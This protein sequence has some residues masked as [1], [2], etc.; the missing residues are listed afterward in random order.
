MEND[1]LGTNTA[2]VDV[3]ERRSELYRTLPRSERWPYTL[4]FASVP[5][6]IFILIYN[7][8]NRTDNNDQFVGSWISFTFAC[9]AALFMPTLMRPASRKFEID[10]IILD[11][12][13]EL[14]E[15]HREVVTVS[16]RKLQQT[17]DLAKLAL[18]HL[19]IQ[20]RRIGSDVP[21]CDSQVCN[22]YQ[23]EV[24]RVSR[25]SKAWTQ[26]WAT[27]AIVSAPMLVFISAN[28]GFSKDLIAPTAA[29]VFLLPSGILYMLDY[30]KNSAVPTQLLHT[31]LDEDDIAR[32]ETND[33]ILVSIT[34][35][36]GERYLPMPP[37]GT[38]HFL[39]T[40]KIAPAE[41]VPLLTSYQPPP[42]V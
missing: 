35:N 37:A 29:L 8:V 2:R 31:E 14:I 6:S 28:F 39:C 23:N 41:E 20:R 4:S 36:T 34:T 26:F 1:N 10:C 24:A 42:P 3:E 21:E 32:R 30:R 33:G 27:S 40:N 12:N 17:G 11:S 18:V 25:A 5:I 15:R 19:E 7:L 9:C 16:P 13:S 38:G 22:H